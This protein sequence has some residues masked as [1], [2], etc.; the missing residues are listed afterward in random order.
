MRALLARIGDRDRVAVEAIADVHRVDHAIF[1][2][3]DALAASFAVLTSGLVGGRHVEGAAV[4]VGIRG[5]V[6]GEEK[7]GGERDSREVAAS[8][9]PSSSER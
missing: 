2:D 8:H 5:I 4:G 1:R 6:A 3:V 9:G 7:A